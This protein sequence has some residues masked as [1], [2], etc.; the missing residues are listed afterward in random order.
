VEKLETKTN[1]RETRQIFEKKWEYNEQLLIDFKKDY[2]SVR[3]A[4]L[5]NIVI[6][7]GIHMNLIRLMKM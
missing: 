6:W 5:Y 1:N 4:V 2:V 3:R 7:F